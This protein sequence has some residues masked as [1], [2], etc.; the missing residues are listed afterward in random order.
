MEMFG[1]RWME[2]RENE[3]RRS[4]NVIY[5]WSF[6]EGKFGMVCVWKGKGREGKN[7]TMMNLEI[8]MKKI[9]RFINTNA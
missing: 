9:Y 2:G 4:K 7:L 6:G 3:G 5:T 8:M 1:E